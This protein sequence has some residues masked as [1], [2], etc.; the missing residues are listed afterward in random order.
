VNVKNLSLIL[1]GSLLASCG[2]IEPL[3]IFSIPLERT[4]LAIEMPAPL[5]P[6]LV[7]W[8]VITPE[9]QE[10]VF[11]KLRTEKYD[12]VLFGLTDDGYENLSMNYAEVRKYIIEQKAIIEAYKQYYEAE[13]E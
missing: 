11:E 12:V 5:E 9:I 4:P 1:A 13:K 8:F 10:K 2:G 7:R 6:K 3:D